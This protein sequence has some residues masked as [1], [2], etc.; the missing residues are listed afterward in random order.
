M[1]ELKQFEQ[2]VMMAVQR[3]PDS[4][5]DEVERKLNWWDLHKNTSFSLIWNFRWS[6]ISFSKLNQSVLGCRRDYCGICAE[7]SRGKC[8]RLQSTFFVNGGASA[9]I[10]AGEVCGLQ[11]DEEF[12]H[13]RVLNFFKVLTNLLKFDCKTRS[14]LSLNLSLLKVIIEMNL[15]L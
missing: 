14:S 8:T 5:P 13:G 1:G 12:A 2:A 7:S 3:H 6:I 10:V 11:H 4:D 9:G 15:F